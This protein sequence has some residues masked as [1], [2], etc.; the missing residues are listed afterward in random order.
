MFPKTMV[1]QYKGPNMRRFLDPVI[2]RIILGIPPVLGDLKDHVDWCSAA[3]RIATPLCSVDHVML[4][5]K[6]GAHVP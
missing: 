3:S 2:L 6:S 4:G 1:D 5:N